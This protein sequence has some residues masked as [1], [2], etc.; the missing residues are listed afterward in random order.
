MLK[1]FLLLFIATSSFAFELNFT[2]EKVCNGEPLPEGKISCESLK[3]LNGISNQIDFSKIFVMGA[4]VSDNY[5]GPHSP[6]Q[7]IA[8]TMNSQFSKHAIGWSSS[9][10]IL[11]DI[12]ENTQKQIDESSMIVAIDM[13]YWNSVEFFWPGDTCPKEIILRDLKTLLSYKK[14]IVLGEVPQLKSE[15]DRGCIDIINGE[16]RKH[17]TKERDCHLISTQNLLDLPSDK[18]AE[19][20]QD[21]GLH[22]SDKGS[23]FIAD[24]ICDELY[25]KD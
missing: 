1:Y 23:H 19:L 9:N 12:N 7:K 16:L 2:T 14:K 25:Q 22:L 5:G 3:T 21:D 10:E 18:Q 13:F 11:E 15:Q 17:C 24:K 8:E 6:G 4:S 20:F